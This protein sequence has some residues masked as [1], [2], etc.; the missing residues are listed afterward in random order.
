MDLFDGLQYSGPG[1]LEPNDSMATAS[2]IGEGHHDIV[3]TGLD[4]LKIDTQA[5]PVRLSMTPATA[6]ANLNME[7]RN[8]A[9]QVVAASFQ[10]SG[11]E[12]INRILSAGGTYYLKIYDPRYNDAP[13][14]GL[15]FGY[16]LEIDLP[17]VVAPDGN[18]TM[19]EATPL[20]EGSHDILGREVDWHRIETEAGYLSLTMTARQLLDN[21]A[22][23]RD[24]TINLNA[25]LV[26]SSG[27]VVRA[28]FS[29]DATE[30]LTYLVPQAGTY[31]LR[32]YT[33]QFGDSP[34]A[35]TLL[36]YNVTLD[37]PDPPVA[38]TNGTMATATLLTRGRTVVTD[39]TGVDWYRVSSGP[40]A[41]SLRL[42]D[43]GA[44]TATNQPMNLNMELYDSTGRLLSAN[45]RPSGDEQITWQTQMGGDHFIK[46]YW[47][48]FPDGA[49]IGN[50]LA[51]E[52][53]ADLPRDSWAR[54][55]D[56]GP[57]RNASVSVYDID[58]DG[59]D[60]IFV[61]TSKALDADANE[62]RPA[63]LIVLEHDGTVKWTKTFAAVAG[64]DPIT[65]KTY[66]TTSVTT[67]PVFSDVNGDGR[68]DI[69]VGVG[70]D[71]AD[72]LTP[73]GQPGDKGGLYA[74]NADGSVLWYHQTR[75]VIGSPSD[76][77]DGRP[78]GIYGAPRVFDIDADGQR[79]VL[80]TAWDHTFYVLNGRTGAVE[81]EVDL[82]DTAGATPAVVDLNGDGLFE[83]VVPS[84]ITNNP[85]AGLPQ[86]GGI[87]RVL[88]NTGLPGV[89]GWKQQVASSTNIDY[90]GRFDEQSLWSSPKIVDL[91][92]DGRPEIVQ[93]TGNFFQDARGSHLK[94][95]NADGS[96]RFQLDAAG[97]TLAAP[98]IADLDGD[99]RPEIIAA[100]MNGHVQ[101]WGADGV[102]RFDTVVQPYSATASGTELPL[103]RQPVAVDLD[104]DN[105]LEIV[106]KVGSQVLVLDHTGQQI[107]NTTAAERLAGS[108]AGSPVVRD[109]DHDG[110]LDILAA[111]TTAAQDQAIVYRWDNIVDTPQSAPRT[112]EYQ[113]APSLHNIQSFVDRFYQTILNRSADPAGRNDWTDNLYTG[114]RSGADVAI[115]FI[116]S[117]E[118]IGRNTSDEQFLNV[119][120]TAFFGRTPDA[121]GYAQWMGKLDAGAS[122]AEVLNG[123]IGSREFSNLAASY[124]IRA[125]ALHGIGSAAAE[126]RGD[127]ADT[128]TLRGNASDQ[129]LFDGASVT[130]VRPNNVDLTGKVFRLY[131]ATL[132]RAPDAGGLVSWLNGLGRDIASGGI[133]LSQAAGGF[134]GSREFQKTYGTL[135]DEAFVNLLYR[136]VLGREADAGGKTFWTG[137]LAGGWSRA[138]VVLGFSES[139]EYQNRMDPA[140]DAYMRKA[141]V[142]WN[143]VLEGGGGNDVLN[144][145][146]GSDIFIFRRG[147]GGHDTIHGFEPWDRL[148]L[149]GFGFAS[150]NDALLAMKQVGTDTVFERG[151]QK[152]TFT[153]TRL[154]DMRR[155][156][157]NL[158]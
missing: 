9:D 132:N 140:L 55:L 121:G 1:P 126:I 43:T 58:N 93:G 37:L 90:R 147:E 36:S 32:V 82:H 20:T 79:E 76:G 15:S 28:N 5:G 22:D 149:S 7:L 3:A 158:S 117:R 109:I 24:D 56:F 61:G 13:P 120:Y 40:G 31:Y 127:I 105:R 14:A 114:V 65:G 75:D 45:L 106:L 25:E 54:T 155:V 143:D 129:H 64:P 81:V 115:G 53:V 131:G 110:R 137:K 16:H 10:P 157:F 144:G 148:Q 97:R 67:A 21:P 153:D 71:N 108:S 19:A 125:Q 70:A 35:G 59:F 88:T 138:D 68:I 30:S 89:P 118:F 141:H 103:V 66:Q 135:D 12:T 152:I 72:A 52:I 49:P 99:G 150:A 27:Q 112:A 41:L 74:L 62:T 85:A 23:P 102:A 122:R 98:L 39:G 17:Q 29:A 26:N 6:G 101:A 33:A 139:R 60:E 151:T 86:Q 2:P 63:G 154:S 142:A 134:V 133:T 124:G 128:S 51:Y 77:P 145:G 116:N 130:E 96:L 84:D 69:L 146:Q 104:G 87:L 111:A 11:T 113:D 73:T 4:W 94:V 46:V 119:L 8:S 38:D 48:A 83:I 50:D 18:N 44:L 95:W 136:N 57:V 78:E 91:D 34:P 156:G 107:T 42:V 123:F 100:T 47:A 92:R 80:V